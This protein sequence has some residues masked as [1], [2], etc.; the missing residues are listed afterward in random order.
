MGKLPLSFFAL[1][2]LL[3]PFL[4]TPVAACTFAGTGTAAPCTF[5]LDSGNYQC[6]KNITVVSVTSLIDNNKVSEPATY[7]EPGRVAMTAE[8]DR[9]ISTGQTL[10]L[11]SVRDGPVPAGSGAVVV[12]SGI[13]D[14][15]QVSMRQCGCRIIVGNV[16]AL[17]DPDTGRISV[18]GTTTGSCTVSGILFAIVNRTTGLAS[19]RK[20]G[21]SV[22]NAFSFS[23]SNSYTS[24]DALNRIDIMMVAYG[25]FNAFGASLPP[26]RSFSDFKV[27]LPKASMVVEPGTAFEVAVSVTNFNNEPDTYAA[28]VSVPQ[29]WSSEKVTFAVGPNSQAGTTIRVTPPKSFLESKNVAVNVVSASSGRT[30]S[31][32]LQLSPSVIK[33]SLQAYLY[34]PR[35]VLIGRPFDAKVVLNATAAG[36]VRY[37]LYTEPFVKMDG[38]EGKAQVTAGLGGLTVS[39]AIRDTCVLQDSA[40]FLRK[41]NVYW[42]VMGEILPLKEPALV[43][44]VLTKIDAYRL[45]VS[46]PSLLAVKNNVTSI[47]SSLESGQNVDSRIASVLGDIDKLKGELAAEENR[48]FSY[49]TCS[50]VGGVDLVLDLISYADASES[51]AKSPIGFASGDVLNARLIDGAGNYVST[52]NLKP[53]D[54]VNLAVEITNGDTVM[55]QFSLEVRDGVLA[56]FVSLGKSQIALGGGQTDTVSVTIQ[57]P[58]VI[59]GTKNA[60]ILVSSSPYVKSLPLIVTMG[61]PEISGSESYTAE[62]GLPATLSFLVR[63]NDRTDD[64]YSLAIIAGTAGTN[65]FTGLPQSLKVAGNKEAKLQLKATPPASAAMGTYNFTIAAS[66]QRGEDEFAFTVV[67]SG[68][69]KS[70]RSEADGIDRIYATVREKCLNQALNTATL[71]DARSMIAAGRLPEAKAKLAS[72]RTEAQS[73]LNECTRPKISIG[74]VLLVLGGLMAAYFAFFVRKPPPAGKKPAP[75]GIELPPGAG[76]GENEEETWI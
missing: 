5:T 46:T 12:A 59:S 22:D 20:T 39:S 41:M 32:S 73:A 71:K 49:K 1:L 40:K 13:S 56:N 45:S 61:G 14:T 4:T 17:F 60:T 31:A 18:S 8:D 42:S 21:Y 44:K 57:T 66:S 16:T 3:L 51:T 38:S 68:E 53:A 24:E 62:P 27:S 76:K 11:Y 6:Q 23:S 36:A 72:A 52:L 75:A 15:G 74:L 50:P 54:V 48:T 29:D 37:F 69:F 19:E 47:A 33:P 64:T 2:L 28:E 7:L 34:Q 67:V 58:T 30:R 65:W 55:R 70:L 63:N 26:M 9:A 25:P 43:R 10:R 35:I